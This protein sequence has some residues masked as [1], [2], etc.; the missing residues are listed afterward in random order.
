[1]CG[2]VPTLLRENP[3]VTS[4]CDL[5]HCGQIQS[6]EDKSTNSYWRDWPLEAQKGVRGEAFHISTQSLPYGKTP[7]N[8]YCS[9][10]S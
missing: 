2:I 1:M 9:R 7:A 5:D 3:D 4:R 6:S 10:T 8:T